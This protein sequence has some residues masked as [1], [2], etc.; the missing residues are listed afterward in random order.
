MYRLTEEL[1]KFIMARIKVPEIESSGP[2]AF[3][4]KNT[5]SV[6]ILDPICATGVDFDFILESPVPI[7]YPDLPYLP[8][9]VQGYFLYKKNELR[10][11][12][13][14]WEIAECFVNPSCTDPEKRIDVREAAVQVA[15]DVDKLVAP[16]V[17]SIGQLIKFCP[18]IIDALNLDVK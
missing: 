6:G 13:E 1:A 11:V 4:P 3:L 14:P 9:G 15:S 8:C 2:N 5:K 16:T 7:L 10:P 17:T 12:E 18:L